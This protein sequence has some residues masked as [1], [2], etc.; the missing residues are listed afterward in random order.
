M[1]NTELLEKFNKIQEVNPCWS[2]YVCFAE[3]ISNKK[4]KKSKILR[5]FNKLI[6]KNEYA[7]A[8]KHI[9][10]KFLYTL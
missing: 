5:Y 9:L 4:Y 1:A 2:S 7:K 8:E 6:D 10:L 3:I